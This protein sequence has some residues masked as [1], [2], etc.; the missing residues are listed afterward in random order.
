MHT[1]W[2]L[3]SFHSI[4]CYRQS[5][6]HPVAGGFQPASA[7]RADM[8]LRLQASKFI[9]VNNDQ[10]VP[11]TNL[12]CR[13]ACE[14]DQQGFAA[15]RGNFKQIACTVVQ[16]IEN[17]THRASVGISYLKPNEI[18][19]IIFILIRSRKGGT[20][21]KQLGAF[22]CRDLFTVNYAT[23]SCNE[24][25]PGS[26]CDLKV[27]GP[28]PVRRNQ[29][30]I[31]GNGLRLLAVAD[32]PCFSPGSEGAG[33]CPYANQPPVRVGFRTVGSGMAVFPDHPAFC[34]A[35]SRNRVLLGCRRFRY[36]LPASVAVPFWDCCVSWAAAVPPSQ[37][38]WIPD[39]SA[40]LLCQANI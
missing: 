17:T 13:L 30:R 5:I 18:V 37:A 26:S 7:E 29:G 16:D 36:L 22:Q 39:R 8:F 15:C 19:A 23:Q 2:Q 27:E 20:V 3:G 32:D 33:D 6:H 34:P 11:E 31:S 12:R 4:R 38:F 25:F 21:R 1:K 9:L 28:L 14:R 10:P 40:L 24:A 35:S